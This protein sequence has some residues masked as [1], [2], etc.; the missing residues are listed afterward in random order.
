MVLAGGDW[1]HSGHTR[2]HGCWEQFPEDELGACRGALSHYGQGSS[3]RGRPGLLA[4]MARNRADHFLTSSARAG[5][6]KGTTSY[7]PHSPS[8]PPCRRGIATIISAF[9]RSTTAI[10][11]RS[12]NA[13]SAIGNHSDNLDHGRSPGDNLYIGSDGGI[14]IL[15]RQH[16]EGSALH[17]CKQLPSSTSQAREANPGAGDRGNEGAAAR[18]HGTVGAPV[19]SS[20]PRQTGELPTAGDSWHTS[21]DLRV[22]HIRSSGCPGPP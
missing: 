21:V 3:P 22:H 9:I 8:P 6:S 4:A 14:I 13:P 16:R 17:V 18:Q 11:R 15:Q 19:G 7:L 10:G 12:S 2:V 5:S 1:R 20:L